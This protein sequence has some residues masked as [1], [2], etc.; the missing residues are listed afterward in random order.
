MSSDNKFKPSSI[1]ISPIKKEIT[2]ENSDFNQQ[3]TVKLNVGENMNVLPGSYRVRIDY[4]YA[5]NPIKEVNIIVKEKETT[6]YTASDLGRLNS[7]AYNS[8]G[9]QISVNVTV[10]GKE[11]NYEYINTVTGNYVDL[12][13]GIN[14]YNILFKYSNSVEVNKKVK[15]NTGTSNLVESKGISS[16]IVHAKNAFGTTENISI[17]VK[18]NNEYI[19]NVEIDKNLFVKPGDY[20]VYCRLGDEDQIKEEII[21]KPGKKESLEFKSTYGG[22][23]VIPISGLGGDATNVSIII[24]RGSEPIK[25]LNG[26]EKIRLLPGE[27]RAEFI[28]SEGNKVNRNVFIKQNE[29]HKEQV[30]IELGVAHIKAQDAMGKSIENSCEIVG[31]DGKSH[32]NKKTGESI[33]LPPGN[34]EVKYK[35]KTFNTNKEKKLVI[36]AGQPQT[37]WIGTETYGRLSWQVKGSRERQGTS[38]TSVFQG[39]KPI[40]QVGYKSYIDL[41]PGTY[42]AEFQI[43]NGPDLNRESLVLIKG[44]ELP[45]ELEAGQGRLEWDITDFKNNTL[46]PSK[47]IIKTSKGNLLERHVGYYKFIDLPPEQYQ[48]KYEFKTAVTSWRTINVVNGKNTD[49]IKNMGRLVF[50]IINEE[51]KAVGFSL[52]I[53]SNGN[54]LVEGYPGYRQKHIDLTPGTYNLAFKLSGENKI[55]KK[56][57][58]VVAKKLDTIKIGGENGKIKLLAKDADG[59][60][61]KNLIYINKVGVSNSK[62]GYSGETITVSPG[63]YTVK[64]P[65]I[66]KDGIFVRHGEEVLV[67]MQ[68]AKASVKF[69]TLDAMGDVID[70]SLG[71]LK[72]DEFVTKINS[73]ETI[74]L[75]PVEHTFKFLY[76]GPFEIVK[77]NVLLKKDQENLI[78]VISDQG[79][80]RW[81]LKDEKGAILEPEVELVSLESERKIQIKDNYVDLMQG[82]YKAKFYHS[83]GL[84]SV[85]NPITIEKGKEKSLNLSLKYGGVKINAVNGL[86]DPASVMAQILQETKVIDSVKSGILKQLPIGNYSAIIPVWKEHTLPYPIRITSNKTEEV[87]IHGSLGKLKVE[88]IDYFGELQ[89]D[90]SPKALGGFYTVKGKRY[91]LDFSNE[92]TSNILVGRHYLSFFI[93]RV[94]IDT[95]LTIQPKGLTT[96]K[97]KEGGIKLSITNAPENSSLNLKVA[98]FGGGTDFQLFNS[99]GILSKRGGDYKLNFNIIDQ[100]N[101]WFPDSIVDSEY[102]KKNLNEFIVRYINPTGSVNVKWGKLTE[103][104]IKIANQEYGQLK[105]INKFYD[106]KIKLKSTNSSNPKYS[107]YTNYSPFVDLEPGL[108]SVKLNRSNSVTDSIQVNKGELT[109]VTPNEDLCMV[110]FKILNLNGNP[111]HSGYGDYDLSISNSKEEDLYFN[112]IPIYC[113]LQEGTYDFKFEKGDEVNWKRNIKVPKGGEITVE[114]GG[115]HRKI[116]PIAKTFLGKTV[117]VPVN[118]YSG[119][120]VSGQSPRLVKKGTSGTNTTLFPADYDFIFKFSDTDSTRVQVKVEPD[121]SVMEVEGIS[122]HAEVSFIAKLGATFETKAPL[123]IEQNGE[124]LIMGEVNNGEYYKLP[125]GTFEVKLFYNN[126]Y[127]N[128]TIKL[129]KGDRKEVRLVASQAR[130]KYLSKDGVHKETPSVLLLTSSSGHLYR[131]YPNKELNVPADTYTLKVDYLSEK[132]ADMDLGQVKFIA[133]TDTLIKAETLGRLKMKAFDKNDQEVNSLVLINGKEG[134]YKSQGIDYQY[135]VPSGSYNLVFSV[136]GEEV[137]KENIGVSAGTITPV[138]VRLSDSEEAKPDEPVAE[139]TEEIDPEKPEEGIPEGMG[140]MHLLAYDGVGKKTSTDVFIYKA[141]TK[142]EIEHFYGTYPNQFPKGQPYDAAPGAYDV[143]FTTGPIMDEYKGVP[144]LEGR[145]TPVVSSGYG[146]L[147]VTVKENTSPYVAFFKAGEDTYDIGHTYGNFEVDLPPGEYEVQYAMGQDSRRVSVQIQGGLISNVDFSGY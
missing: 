65:T 128:K 4:R 47:L 66:E 83:M 34:Y 59:V 124:N 19:R 68:E 62:T 16:I 101:E 92:L 125:E 81:E 129:E 135:D 137:K 95:L 70:V 84:D 5:D 56:T 64:F 99:D 69:K 13:G 44:K 138:E 14:E 38:H 74:L 122:P 112:H 20:V 75:D 53:N 17:S 51:G 41:P 133:T 126:R 24:Y 132:M 60:E 87:T 46:N 1:L 11:Q 57:I 39:K 102:N 6:T 96:F 111:I 23:E 10:N 108:Y 104:A 105:L 118:I 110:N 29:L 113:Y 109:V 43:E 7:K 3:N 30:K 2:E 114:I 98:G 79:R 48:I 143:F 141:G 21:L 91:S 134:E 36:T 22:L 45:I 116:L 120:G 33:E 27:Y 78:E 12:V 145:I 121:P 142:E 117:I 42:R 76:P 100:I 97:I 85:V 86:G 89:K 31:Q 146:R 131:S 58:T 28:Y 119:V 123:E 18:H 94:P 136:A 127:H 77:E 32:G 25:Y 52:D 71:V 93:M 26:H 40:I 140:R 82:K 106:E 103:V 9:N 15:I 63:E 115:E 107:E 72:G 50:N 88:L 55:R 37:V 80:L 144:V 139:K 90:Y 54:L 147:K 73:S 67:E 130:I 35:D 8:Q 49:V 61:L